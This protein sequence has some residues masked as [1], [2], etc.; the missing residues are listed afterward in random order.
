MSARPTPPQAQAGLVLPQ[1]PLGRCVDWLARGWQDL[2][3][4]PVVALVHGA[5]MALFGALLWLFAADRF[6]ILAGAFSGFLLVAPVLATGLYAV[7]RALEQGRRADFGSVMAVWL[8]G[9]RRLMVFGLLLALAGS[10]WVL[11]SAAMITL[12]APQAVNTPAD[13]IRHVVL[14]ESWLFEAWV[15][16]GGVLAAPMFASSVIAMPM[17]LDRSVGVLTAVLTSWRAVIANPAP[18]ALWAAV[19]LLLTFIGMATALVG[20]IVLGPLLGHASWH[21]YR[22]LVRDAA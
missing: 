19:I 5:L 3:R 1:V 10:G 15:M 22:D 20:L 4:A 17:L 9:H 6:R 16:M 21:A 14:G 2:Q 12:W 13:F 8:S 18:L 7:S 11:T